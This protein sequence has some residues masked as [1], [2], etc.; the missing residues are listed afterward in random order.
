MEIKT[1]FGNE[2]VIT[3]GIDRRLPKELVFILWQTLRSH[4]FE[5]LMSHRK[6]DY[7]QIFELSSG[8]A[9][10]AL[11]VKHLQEQP[12]YCRISMVYLSDAQNIRELYGV[13][14]Y[15]ID[16]GTHSTMLFPE[17]Y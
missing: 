16:D 14:V 6:V 10:G 15:V 12:H 1:P 4:V 2:K 5:D 13:K 9:P 3:C 11:T 7:F 8:E 17:E